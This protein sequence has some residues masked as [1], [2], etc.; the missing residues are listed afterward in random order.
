MERNEYKSKRKKPS[1]P[2]GR[3][4][5]KGKKAK[6]NV[7]SKVKYMYER[8]QQK[9]AKRENKLCPRDTCMERWYAKQ[10]NSEGP[11]I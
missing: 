6:Q 5:C 8:R 3:A 9:E 4:K 11:T 10:G 7:P 2:N 1:E